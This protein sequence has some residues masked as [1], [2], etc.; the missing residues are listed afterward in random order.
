MAHIFVTCPLA[1][2]VWAWVKLFWSRAAPSAPPTIFDSTFTRITGYTSQLHNAQDSTLWSVIHTYTVSELYA[3]RCT[4]F[5]FANTPP[6][7][8]TAVEI[9]ARKI[10]Q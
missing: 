8:R 4:E 7:L 5:V 6:T 9:T 3:T 2:G 1:R 10:I